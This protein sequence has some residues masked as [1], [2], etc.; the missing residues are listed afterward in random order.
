MGNS[1][2]SPN[3]PPAPKRAQAERDLVKKGFRFV[4][5]QKCAFC[6]REFD[7]WKTP[8]GKLI[9]LTTVNLQPHWQICRR[10]FQNKK[11]ASGPK[12]YFRRW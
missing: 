5:R 3:M 8:R 9:P 2:D 10:A 12:P 1:F 7:W 4:A 6:K 11:P